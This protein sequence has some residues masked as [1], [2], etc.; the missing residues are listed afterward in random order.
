MECIDQG[1]Y[2][3]W[4]ADLDGLARDQELRAEVRVDMLTRIEIDGFKTFTDFQ[5]DVSPFVAIVG[6]NA[7]GKSNLFDAL[8]LLS[9]LSTYDLAEAFT[10][11]RGEPH[12][13]FRR[14]PDG[15]FVSRMKLAA[16]LLLSPEVRDPWGGAV[17]IKHNRLR[18]EV[19]IERR[20]D[21]REIERLFVIREEAIPILSRDDRWRTGH[22]TTEAHDQLLTY[23]RRKPLLTTADEDGKQVFHVHQDGHQGR[24][25]PATAAEATVLSSMTSVDFP[26]LFALREEFR[27]WRYL[28]IDPAAVRRASP[29]TAR[30]ILERNGSNLATVLARIKATTASET[31]PKGLVSDIALDLSSVIPGLLDLDVIEDKVN[32]ENRVDVTMRD[33][34]PFPSRV[35]SD[36]TLRVLALLTMLH[37]PQHGGLLCFEEPENGIHPGRL[38]RLIDLI[39]EAVRGLSRATD[40]REWGSWYQVIVN[41]HS[42]AVLSK[43]RE[44]EMLFAD[45]IRALP[46]TGAGFEK[47]T[48]IRPV[49]STD[50]GELPLLETR[51]FVERFEVRHYL[52]SVERRNGDVQ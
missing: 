24:K 37:D 1:G 13:L 44:G 31:L 45:M 51:E 6:L 26:H 46:Q 28:Q 52:S 49:R 30:E 43:L 33:E 41:S 48:R 32:R 15:S 21:H 16:E 42:P 19:V 3:S 10:G 17:K 18:Y 22:G 27:S 8:E 11:L 38:S 39:R 7:S 20:R 12:E 34:L 47:R 36:G 9:R 35:L 14:R 40:R 29:T 5:L 50:E 23:G 2:S 4:I 25:R